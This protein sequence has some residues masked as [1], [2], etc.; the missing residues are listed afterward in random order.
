MADVD[1]INKLLGFARRAGK[2]AVGRSA[3][4]MAEKQ[5]RLALVLLAGD[6]TPKA[7]RIVA[8]LR[9]I[10]SIRYATK[11]ELGALLGRDEVG[12]VGILDQNFA[13]SIKKAASD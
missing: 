1:R 9:G 2:L 12:M 5:K 10:P 13:V 3:V 7:E 11:D 4:L 8:H 6:A